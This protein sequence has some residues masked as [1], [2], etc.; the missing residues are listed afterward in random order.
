MAA[1]LIVIP[2]ANKSDDPCILGSF[3]YLEEQLELFQGTVTC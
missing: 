1:R 3:M 2:H